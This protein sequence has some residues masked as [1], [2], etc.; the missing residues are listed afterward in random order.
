MRVS[1]GR[2]VVGREKRIMV[3]IG[4]SW[5][6]EKSGP[7]QNGDPIGFQFMLLDISFIAY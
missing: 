1:R 7:H 4:V 6:T 5:E 3:V 2:W